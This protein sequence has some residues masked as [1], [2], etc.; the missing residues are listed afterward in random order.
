MRYTLQKLNT[1]LM[2][3][4]MAA[5]V[6]VY[7][8]P[9]AH[10]ADAEGV[11][12]A[13]LTW[14]LEGGTLT[15]EGSGA[16]TDFKEPDMAPWYPYR[17]EVLRLSLP[18]G[19]TSIGDLAFYECVGLTTVVIPDTVTCIG[20][21]ALAQCGK[22]V[23]VMLGDGLQIIGDN[24]FSGCG[25]LAGI[26]I[27]SGVEVIG[28]K[29]F[30]RCSSLSRITIPHSVTEIGNSAFG[31]CESLVK[32]DIQ[33]NIEVL[34]EFIFYGCGSLSVVQL[35][36]SLIGVNEFSFR[37]CSHLTTV[38]Y[39]GEKTTP[40]DIQQTIGDAVPEFNA[41]GAVGNG[42]PTDTVVSGNTKEN[43]D[44]TV[45][46]ENITVTEKEDVTV[47]TKVE[48][49]FP[50]NG[51]DGEYNAEIDVDV[52]GGN[53][54]KGAQEVVKE[55]LDNLG[56]M[57]SVAGQ[58]ETVDVNVYVRDPNGMDQGFVDALSGRDVKINVTAQNGSAWRVDAMRIV[59]SKSDQYDLT[60]SLDVGSPE[61]CGE[62]QTEYC[63]VLKFLK[64]AQ[65]NAEV[66]IN[67]GPSWN[68]QT[69]TLF[70][71]EGS[72]LTRRQSVVVDNNGYAHF[73]LASVNEQTEYYIAMNLPAAAEEAIVPDELMQTTNAVRLNPIE[74]EITGRTSSWNVD[75][76]QVTKIM[77]AIIGISVVLVGGIMFYLNKVKLK[78]GYVPSVD[79]WDE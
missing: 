31:Y 38:Y 73:F 53:G 59:E 58:E 16:M 35:P 18:E 48:H 39:N 20:D 66:L 14:T 55:S 56:H 44:G 30:Y 69:A 51:G 34:P 24:A 67:L 47:T 4:L 78:L 45:T 64:P 27:P 76:F 29:A 41:T 74:Y 77:V 46:Q 12:G 7:A 9:A 25:K 63:F 62:M 26:S 37:G 15:I 72:K 79:D 21:Y 10:A 43:G 49:T 54:W 52:S 36:S 11:C 33:A 17:D 42:T 22:L 1:R 8:A 13:D 71:R 57:M 28:K 65:I 40:E 50:E 61:L 32:A 2:A 60:Y 5:M 68:R 6:L 70:Q 3:L 23:M 75:I 19:L